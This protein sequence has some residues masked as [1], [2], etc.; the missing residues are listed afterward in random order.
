[1]NSHYDVV[2]RNVNELHKE[3][4]EPHDSKTNGSGQSNF[5]ELCTRKKGADF[6]ILSYYVC[7]LHN[8]LPLKSGFVHL[9]T[10]LIESLA[11]S[12]TGLT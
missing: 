10:S 8:V 1:M 3:S 6:P 12:L 5:L 9:L 7:G 2:D 4:N 11:N